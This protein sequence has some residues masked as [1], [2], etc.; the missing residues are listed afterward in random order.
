M[1]ILDNLI[2]NLNH[3]KI[4][5]SKKVFVTGIASDSRKVRK[6][7]IYV[8]I[9]GD[10]V[11][12]SDFIKDALAH[13]ASVIVSEKPI[14]IIQPC[15]F[16]EVTDARAA[17]AI[18]ST[19]FYGNPSEKMRLIGI[20]GTNGKTTVSHLIE[21][22]LQE[23]NHKTGLIGTIEYRFSDYFYRSNKTTPE[24]QFINYLFAKMV[25]EEVDTAVMEVSSHSLK[26]KRVMGLDFD[27]A[28]FT[29][30]TQ[31]HLDYHKTLEDYIES[32]TSLFLQLDTKRAKNR[33]AIINTDDPYGQYICQQMK[34]GYI[35]Y[36]IDQPADIIATDIRYDKEGTYFSV[37]YAS[38]NEDFFIPLLGKHNVYN[39]LAAIGAGL[40][41]GFDF[42]SMRRSL[43]AFAGVPGRLQR[44]DAS[45]PFSVY[46]DYAH[47]EDALKQV[48]MTLRSAHK[49]KLYVLFGCG[50]DRDPYKRPVM[51][52]VACK[53]ADF[54]VI[55]SD[56]PRSE[57]PL[58]I[59]RQ[60][61]KGFWSDNVYKV[62]PD[63]K[64][65]INFAI[66]LCK[67]DDVLLIAGKGHEKY[68]IIGDTLYPFDDAHIVK[69]FLYERYCS[70]V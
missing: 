3:K 26:Q 1:T 20:T 24:S 62:I 63:R 57:N 30:L 29:N 10:K 52:E 5:G 68:Q 6:D 51:G 41:M 60:I 69:E 36:G 13:G 27:I 22:M 9:K 40:L 21:S 7:F 44:I 2:N 59:I 55:T 49:G 17:L 64:E 39:T 61:Q 38:Y 16:I 70:A 46:V 43:A 37:E 53:Y 34:E 12:G 48:L 42:G 65:A 45:Q 56:N 33:G 31:D 18:L 23:L 14:D 50:G 28:I 15:T 35:T 47:T 32:K 58:N 8:A 25:E 67:A 66:S 4:I 19:N 11:D 54:T